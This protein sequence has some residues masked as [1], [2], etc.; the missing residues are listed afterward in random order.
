MEEMESNQSVF[1]FLAKAAKRSIEVVNTPIPFFVLHFTI[2]VPHPNAFQASAGDERAAP[3][4]VARP[5]R[6]TCFDQP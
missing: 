1:K 2:V 6:L 3:S 5:D 4:D